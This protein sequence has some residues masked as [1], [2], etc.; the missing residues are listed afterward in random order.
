MSTPDTRLVV[1]RHGESM[2]QVNGIISGHNTC[3]GLSDLGRAQAGA[4]RD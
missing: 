2:A 1:I 3:V 4:L